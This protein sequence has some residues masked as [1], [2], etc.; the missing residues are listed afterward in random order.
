MPLGL[1]TGIMFK[2]NFRADGE[3]RVNVLFPDQTVGLYTRSLENE[4]TL[5]IMVDGKIV[6]REPIGG[7]EDLML[8]HRLAGDGRA[9]ILERFTKVPIQVQA[10]V[11]DVVVGFIERSQFESTANTGGGRLGGNQPRLGDVEIVGPYNSTGVSSPSRELV[12]VCDPDTVGEAACA[13]QIT[14]NLA[15]RAFRRPATEN[16]VARLLPFHEAGRTEGGSFDAGVA[17]LVAAVLVSPDFLYRAIRVPESSE[18]DLS[19]LELASRLSFFIWNTGPGRGIA[20]PRGREPSQRAGRSGRAGDAHARRSESL[21]P[22]QQLRD[23][24]AGAGQ[25]GIRA[26]GPHGVPGIR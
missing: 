13:R 22:G 9:E 21:Q 23:E 24:V 16:D 25:S 10:G 15:T 20:R 17:R 5:V 1:R 12:Y 2:H 11:R 3:Y 8:N 19:G 4:N 26:A 18:A 7:L 14:E 6:F